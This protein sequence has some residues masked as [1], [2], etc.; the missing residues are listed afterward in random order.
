MVKW[1]QNSLRLLESEAGYVQSKKNREKKN[2]NS[3]GLISKPFIEPPRVQVSSGGLVRVEMV[4]VPRESYICTHMHGLL[5]V[6]TG[7]E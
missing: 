7:E 1:A 5:S 2:A 6:P 4:P 3:R